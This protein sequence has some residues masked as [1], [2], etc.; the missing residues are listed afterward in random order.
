ML[1]FIITAIVFVLIFSLL[2]LVH[3][4]GHFWMAKRAGIKVEEFGLGLP[5]RIWGKKKG[6]TIY[7]VNWIPFGGFVRMYGEDSKSKKMLSSNRS[8]VGKSARDRIKVVVAGVVMNF[9][10]AWVLLTV[11]FTVG[12]EPLLTPDEV[13]SAV[14]EERVVLEPGVKVKSSE[15]E[16]FRADDLVYLFN[17]QPVDNMAFSP[18]TGLPVGD[19]MLKRDGKDISVTLSQSQSGK[20]TF[21]EVVNFPRVAVSGSSFREGD[22]ILRV[23]DTE[24]FEISDLSK[25]ILSSGA[26]TYDVYNQGSVRQ[27]ILNPPKDDTVIV[28][29]VLPGS[30]A[31]KAGLLKGD[32]IV[33]VNNKKVET[34]MDVI[35]MIKANPDVGL[36]Y[37]LNRDEEVLNR[38]LKPE[39]GMVGVVLAELVYLNDENLVLYDSQLLSSVAEIKQEKYPFYTAP[40]H[41]LKETYR[42]SVLTADMFGNVLV[43]LIKGGDVPDSVAG[44]VGIAQMTHVFV[45]EGFMSLLRFVAILSLSLAVIN[46]LPFPALDGGRLLFILVEIVIGR[47]IDQRFESYVHAFGYILL[48]LLIFAVTYNDIVK[49][50]N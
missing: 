46:I 14:S 36:V 15:N 21:Y 43:G 23:N 18:D 35:E 44:P 40:L 17:G 10:L 37:S 48:L 50:I 8:F 4:L 6:E 39:N 47:R 19:Y 24:V 42:L 11:G 25:L 26:T 34:P 33:E 32:M 38:E 22:M 16:I 49:L 5:P 3:E 27:V 28:S 13:F 9:F 2:V 1:D 31:E 12:M 41:A 45:Q 20:V 30:P 29:Q 7:S